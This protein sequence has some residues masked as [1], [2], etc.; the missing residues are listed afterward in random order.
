MQRED[1]GMAGEEAF[2]IRFMRATGKLRALF[3]PAQQGSMTGPV[4]YRND[5]AQKQRQQQLEQW[6]VVRGPGGSTYLV[7]RKPDA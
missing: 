5:E 2:A 7:S 4:V 3:G 1:H 6:D